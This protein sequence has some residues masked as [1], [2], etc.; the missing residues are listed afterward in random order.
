MYCML[1]CPQTLPRRLALASDL[2]LARA[3]A[4]PQERAAWGEVWGGGQTIITGGERLGLGMG[5][6]EI[7]GWRGGKGKQ[8]KKGKVR[9][10]RVR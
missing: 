7:G 2:S 6:S 5:N 3:A 1:S 4:R 8:R 9:E 10:G